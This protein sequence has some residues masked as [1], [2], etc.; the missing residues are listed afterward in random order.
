MEQFYAAIKDN[1]IFIGREFA[2]KKILNYIQTEDIILELEKNGYVVDT[3]ARLYCN[4][5]IRKKI[6]MNEKNVFNII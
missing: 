2:L 6:K 1:K 4:K 3:L 5:I